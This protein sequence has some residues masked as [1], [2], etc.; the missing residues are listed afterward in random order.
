MPVE[1]D[2]GSASSEGP[3]M[4]DSV[5]ESSSDSNTAKVPKWGGKIK[6][7]SRK[8]W[9][10]PTQSVNGLNEMSELK[11][12]QLIFTDRV[13]KMIIRHTLAY[14]IDKKKSLKSL[15]VGELKCFLGLHILMSLSY[16]QNVKD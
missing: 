2:S 13:L 8:K 4:M 1:I 6:R 9:R 16:K 11:A 3:M 14:S 15:E 12:F 5:S 7:I 10:G